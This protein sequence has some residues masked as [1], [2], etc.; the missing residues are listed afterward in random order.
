MPAPIRILIV[1]DHRAVAEGLAA[2]L[3]SYDGISV[4]GLARDGDGAVDIVD[5]ET[6]DLALLDI[7]LP[8]EDGFEVGQR[9]IARQPSIKRLFWSMYANPEFILRAVGIGACGYL[10]KEDSAHD[11]AQAILKAGRGDPS[12]SNS[13]HHVAAAMNC[14]LHPN[15]SALPLLSSVNSDLQLSERER[16]VL[17][18]MAQGL[19][20]S[21]IAEQLGLTAGTVRN[22]WKRAQDKLRLR[23]LPPRYTVFP[24]PDDPGSNR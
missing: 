24:D 13:I 22:F 16:A 10:L 3:G 12:F 8:F 21:E 19:N 11:I 1:D 7:D 6:V 9:L 14:E 17:Q 20:R 23:P 18:L 2:V 15:V 4:Q 5:R